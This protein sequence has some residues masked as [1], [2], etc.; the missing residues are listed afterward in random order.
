MLLTSAPNSVT[1]CNYANTGIVLTSVGN[2]SSVGSTQWS[3]IPVAG[4][5]NTYNIQSTYTN[6][7]GQSYVSFCSN[8]CN[9]LINW[10]ADTHADD[11]ELSSG[12][13]QWTIS[14]VSSAKT[15]VTGA[16]VILNVQANLFLAA[17]ESNIGN[18]QYWDSNG[19]MTGVCLVSS[20]DDNCY[21]TVTS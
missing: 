2:S 12:Y 10:I 13:T 19:T 14:P 3:F 7:N 15:G 8:C 6:S 20:V 5:A 16:V 17:W 18:T 21:W 9:G 1:S 11:T 4:I